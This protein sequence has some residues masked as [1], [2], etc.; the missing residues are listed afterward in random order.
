MDRREVE[1]AD[2][3]ADQPPVAVARDQHV[4]RRTA[5]PARGPR[6][7]RV[8]PLR[9]PP[10]LRHQGQ[11]LV[12]EGADAAA[13]MRQGGVDVL[14]AHHLPAGGAVDDEQVKAEQAREEG[15][16][17]IALE[18]ALQHLSGISSGPRHLAAGG[19]GTDDRPVPL[20]HAAR[21]DLVDRHAGLVADCE[22]RGEG[23]A[24]DGA[25]ALDGLAADAPGDAE[26]GDA[27]LL[28][29]ERA[30]ILAAVEGDAGHVVQAAA[31]RGGG[32]GR[33]EGGEQGQGQG[34]GQGGGLGGGP[35][36]GQGGGERER[37]TAKHGNASTAVSA[38]LSSGPTRLPFRQCRQSGRR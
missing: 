32:C 37:K 9:Q 20:Q 35:G 28:E 24:A 21:P 7:G 2:H 23:E 4:G 12:P 30:A 27:D 18:E 16:D 6:L 33:G 31:L 1:A 10:Q 3:L 14:D 29:L 38:W 34:G 17:A 11:V 25:H 5:G 15:L 36:G 26:R 22:R 19:E 13:A 8:A